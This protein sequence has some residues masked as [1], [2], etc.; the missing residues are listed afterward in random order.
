MEDCSLMAANFR[1]ATRAQ[2]YIELFPAAT[3]VL[4]KLGGLEST[5]DSLRY[6]SDLSN[7]CE[8]VFRSNSNRVPV[9]QHRLVKL[10]SELENESNNFASRRVIWQVRFSMSQI[11]LGWM[12]QIVSELDVPNMPSGTQPNIK[13]ETCGSDEQ[14]AITELRLQQVLQTI[15]QIGT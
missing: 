8:F 2:G 10:T 14:Q 12:L 1:R 5:Y 7:L 6:G 3:K 13:F 11:F 4:L 15:W 9:G